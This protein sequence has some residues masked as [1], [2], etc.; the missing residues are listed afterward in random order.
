MGNAGRSIGSLARREGMGCA[1][2]GM[3]VGLF[4]QFLL[5]LLLSGSQE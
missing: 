1:V 3:F 4:P 2:A 5:S